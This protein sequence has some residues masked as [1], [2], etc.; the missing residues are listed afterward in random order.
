MQ[1][2]NE[3]KKIIKKYKDNQIMTYDQKNSVLEN[4]R[5]NEF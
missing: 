3:Y 5:L 1:E 2:N 4:P